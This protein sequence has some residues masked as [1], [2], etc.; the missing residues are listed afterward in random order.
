MEKRYVKLRWLNQD[1]SDH[2]VVVEIDNPNSNHEF[3][4]LEEEDHVE[5]KYNNFRLIDLTREEL[6]IMGVP[7]IFDDDDDDDDDYDKL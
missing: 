1:F 7:A 5:Q 3:N 4:R 2:E 6:Y